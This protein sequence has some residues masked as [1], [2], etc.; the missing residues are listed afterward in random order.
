MAGIPAD[1]FA[2]SKHRQQKCWTQLLSA[3]IGPTTTSNQEMM[4]ITCCRTANGIAGWHV[5][6]LGGGICRS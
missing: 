3:S 2:A 5:C 4:G 1:R 6:W